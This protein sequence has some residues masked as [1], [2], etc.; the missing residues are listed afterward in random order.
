M[1]IGIDCRM[2]S[3]RFTGIGR[4]TYELVDQFIKINESKSLNHEFVLF[5]NDPE[6]D[7]Y[8]PPNQS[9]KKVLVN[10]KH[11]SFAEQTRFLK[12]LNSAACDIVHFP[13]FNVPLLYRRPYTVTIHDLTLSLFPGQKMTKWYHRRAYRTIIKN[14]VTRA[15]KVITVSNSTKQ[16]IISHLH[17]PEEKIKVIHNGISAAFRPVKDQAILQ[18]TLSKFSITQPF[19][20]YTGVWRSH[21]NLTGL[22]KA[23]SILLTTHK[24]NLRLVITG[25]PDPYYPE[26]MRTAK[27]LG[28]MSS[29][30]FPG[31]V[32]EEDLVNLYNAAN[33]YVFPSFYEGFGLPP[34][35]AMK[36][37]TPVAAS[38]TSSIPEICG[39]ENAVFFDPKSPEDIAEKIFELFGNADLRAK[40]IQKGLSHAA[41]FTWES[42]G[43][44]TFDT[45]LS[46]LN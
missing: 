14:A 41:S 13:H 12:A 15:K 27:D 18:K 39:K 35:E 9:V 11:Y 28:L 33:I 4:Y 8:V 2:F 45:I 29:V 25:K 40:L 24:L 42:S 6:Y 7:A 31:L 20:L 37:G 17:I 16:D 10:A 21:K 36:C 44:E 5:F 3:S 19:L 34:L 32:N 23:F 38:A 26:V 46:S 43:R 30:I 1:R 22:L